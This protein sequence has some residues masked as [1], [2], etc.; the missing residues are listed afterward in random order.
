MS[1]AE[2]VISRQDTIASVLETSD[3][4]FGRVCREPESI[5]EPSWYP[6][7][8]R[9]VLNPPERTWLL[10]KKH[11]PRNGFCLGSR[12]APV[13]G[14]I[15]KHTSRGGW[16]GYN[17]LTGMCPECETRRGL[18]SNG[19]IAFHGSSDPKRCLDFTDPALAFACPTCKVAIGEYCLTIAPVKDWEGKDCGRVRA[20][21]HRA[22]KRL[23]R[24]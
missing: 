8:R 16:S 17:Y 12:K 7:L 5:H 2:Q 6:E 11:E 20:M 4:H 10:K 13:Q 15:Q 19:R 9:L 21:T 22:R 14:T 23:V 3:G 1:A 24:E 18:L